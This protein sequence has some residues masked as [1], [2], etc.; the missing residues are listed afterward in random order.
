[1]ESGLASMS[2]LLIVAVGLALLWRR[3]LFRRRQRFI[4]VTGFGHAPDKRLREA[5]PELGDAQRELIVSGLR[6]YFKVVSL[7]GKKGVSMPSQA[8]DEAWHAL[9]LDTR[10]YQL[11]CERAFGRFLHHV[12][13][14]SMQ[15]PQQA[16]AG[17]RRCWKFACKLEGISPQRPTRLPRLF[18]IDTLLHIENGFRYSLD[19]SKGDSRSGYCAAHIG[20]SSGGSCISDASGDSSGCS[21]G[22]GGD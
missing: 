21:G 4:D 6:D 5:Y 9:I 1:M 12:P 18:A 2:V 22:C 15:S 16:Q 10:R 13:A 3:Q 19:C 7:A 17:I 20:C 11:Y 14:E 8:V